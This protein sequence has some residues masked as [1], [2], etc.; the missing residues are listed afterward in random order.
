MLWMV[1]GCVAL[2]AFPTVVILQLDFVTEMLVHQS[3]GSSAV[4]AG[5][6]L[7]TPI[8]AERAS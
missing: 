4:K 8:Q 6:L 5:W 3:L 1:V 7:L 2:G